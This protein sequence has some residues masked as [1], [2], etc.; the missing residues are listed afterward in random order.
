MSLGKEIR[1]LACYQWQRARRHWALPVAGLLALGAGLLCLADFRN[2]LSIEILMMSLSLVPLVQVVVLVAASLLAGRELT[3]GSADLLW[4]T[5]LSNS[6]IICGKLLGLAPLWLLTT[7]AYCLVP[8]AAMTMKWLPQG[9]EPGYLGLELST[10]FLS[11]G[12][13]L[14]FAVTL[15]AILGL[16][17]R[18]IA[19]FATLAATWGI[20]VLGAVA[21][22][23]YFHR[24]IWTLFNSTPLPMAIFMNNILD[25]YAFLPY[26]GFFRAHAL[27]YLAVAVALVL[28]P[29]LIIRGRRSRGQKM[30]ATRLAALASLVAVVAAGLSFYLPYRQPYVI[31][32][33]E[34]AYY[35]QNALQLGAKDPYGPSYPP[36]S[37]P[38]NPAAR[39]AGTANPDEIARAVEVFNP[40][41]HITSYDL[42]VDLSAPPQVEVQAILKLENRGSK[43]LTRPWLALNHNFRVTQAKWSQGSPIS[44]RYDPARAD[45]F[46]LEGLTLAPGEGGYLELTYQGQAN[47]WWLGASASPPQLVYYNHPRTF[48][49]APEYGW[50]PLPHPVKFA[51][52]STDQRGQHYIEAP[53]STAPRREW[54]ALAPPT[55]LPGRAH[56]LAKQAGQTTDIWTRTAHFQVEVTLAPAQ[57]GPGFMVLS[58]LGAAT[59]AE[60]TPPAGPGRTVSLAGDS[61]YLYLMGSPGMKAYPGPGGTVYAASEMQVEKFVAGGFRAIEFMQQAWD[62]FGVSP[63]SCRVIAWPAPR[64]NIGNF[65]GDMMDSIEGFYLGNWVYLVEQRSDVRLAICAMD[66]LVGRRLPSGAE[67][68]LIEGLL[69]SQSQQKK[70]VT[71]EGHYPVP[72][73]DEQTPPESPALPTP[74]DI[75]KWIQGHDPET[76]KATMHRLYLTAR[77][78]PLE[79]QDLAPFKG[80]QG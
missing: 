68:R 55:G 22:L 41:L 35:Y 47:M 28:V 67:S 29:A 58:N 45:G 33:Q 31:S 17:L 11:V 44:V 77:K 34:A 21:G 18:G 30:L 79:P 1:T 10:L 37:G 54:L 69:E 24:P 26:Q 6:G 5:P 16:V 72:W 75:A 4:V 36:G 23:A 64:V 52:V 53:G 78:R 62:L 32:E 74:A 48:Y 15:G 65:G 60:P 56:A 42:H 59:P 66:V 71:T 51:L 73:E 8:A 43:E 49:L 27:T 63:R 39:A 3:E 38:V 76:V 50:Y 20:S 12:A 40:P 19:L 14:A 25:A 80:G 7:L 61:A 2:N 70:I 13:S 9:L 57:S 46:Y